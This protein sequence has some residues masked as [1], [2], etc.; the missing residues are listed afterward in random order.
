MGGALLSSWGGFVAGSRLGGTRRRAALVGTS[1]A[2]LAF[3]PQ[4]G[5]SWTKYR[6]ARNA[7]FEILVGWVGS[8]RRFAFLNLERSTPGALDPDDAYPERM[9]AV[10]VDLERGTWRVAGSVDASAFSPEL[11]FFRRTSILGVDAC[12]RFGLYEAGS[13]EPTML[14]ARTGRVMDMERAARTALPEPADFGLASPPRAY[15]ITWAGLGQAI[16]FRDQDEERRQIFRDPA[17]GRPVDRR[18]I[19]PDLDRAY[20]DV[21]V[22]PGDWLAHDG[23]DWWRFDPASGSRELLACLSNDDRVGPSVTD[24]TLLV[25]REGQLSL[26]DPDTGRRTPISS[27]I[28]LRHVFV[29][30]GAWFRNPPLTAGSTA[31]VWAGNESGLGLGVLDLAERSLR[32]D[33]S[34]VGLRTLILSTAGL[35]VITIEQGQRLVLRSYVPGERR[36]RVLFSTEWMGPGSS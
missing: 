17:G 14:E 33:G 18:E 7:P 10:V 16:R 4:W 30:D 5:W 2:V 15:D 21:R 27:D 8:G 20:A 34:T 36:V 12:E 19:L 13:D 11:R 32:V 24:G 3:L 25:V 9:T 23:N 26:L 35:R 22:R 6:A 29:G 31:V 28:E 1:L